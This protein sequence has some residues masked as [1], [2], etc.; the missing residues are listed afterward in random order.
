MPTPQWYKVD[1]AI[2]FDITSDGTSGEEW[3]E[4]LEDKGDFVDGYGKCLLRSRDFKPTSGVTSRVCVLR[5]VSFSTEER[6]TDNIQVKAQ[7]RG[8][9]ELRAEAACLI[10][11]KFTDEELQA[12]GLSWIV[13]MKLLNTRYYPGAGYLGVRRGDRWMRR[14][15]YQ[16]DDKDDWGSTLRGHWHQ[17]DGKAAWGSVYGF[18]YAIP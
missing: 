1:T 10:R 13:V 11:E 9:I 2:C 12:M 14:R 6:A 17:P 5:G 8:L 3:I 4:R 15:S 16:P 7:Q 18:A